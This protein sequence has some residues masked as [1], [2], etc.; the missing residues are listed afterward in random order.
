V[1][2]GKIRVLERILN[3]AKERFPDT[4]EW[5]WDPEFE[6]AIERSMD[7]A[8]WGPIAESGRRRASS[9]ASGRTVS[10]QSLDPQR[11]VGIGSAEKR[12]TTLFLSVAS[13]ER[14]ESGR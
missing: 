5:D 1:L 11:S 10:I 14:I 2:A 3:D 7:Q 8:N 4:D 9:D 12:E 13:E 6:A